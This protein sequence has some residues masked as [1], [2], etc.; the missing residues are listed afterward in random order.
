MNRWWRHSKARSPEPREPE[1]AAS[2][3][4]TDAQFDV[5]PGL[6]LLELRE[7]GVRSTADFQRAILA[8]V[9]QREHVGSTIEFALGGFAELTY[10][11]ATWFAS[12]DDPPASPMLSSPEP[13]G[14]PPWEKP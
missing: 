13:E 9:E 8:R 14:D 7:Y 2:D 5:D 6:P 4:S 1:P 10:T 12:L 11:Y 3:G